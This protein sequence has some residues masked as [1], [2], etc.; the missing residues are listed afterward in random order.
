[1]RSN[2]MLHSETYKRITVET[3]KN[4]LLDVDINNFFFVLTAFESTSQIEVRTW[5]KDPI[6]INELSLIGRGRSEL[7]KAIARTQNSKDFHE[8]DLELYE[9]T[10][11]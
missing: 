7:I 4:I 11:I 6:I 9:R 10:P 8:W 3:I 1:M 5:M 2:L